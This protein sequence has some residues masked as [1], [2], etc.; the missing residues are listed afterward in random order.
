MDQVT[1]KNL[2]AKRNTFC[3]WLEYQTFLEIE[4]ILYANQGKDSW[5]V[6]I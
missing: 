6:L 2:K 1:K 4:V 3:F 5:N